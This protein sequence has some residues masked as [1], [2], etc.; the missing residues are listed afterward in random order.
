MKNILLLAIIVLSF[1]CSKQSA[2][3][4]P[5]AKPSETVLKFYGAITR[6]DSATFV[7]LVCSTIKKRFA[8][9]PQFVSYTFEKWKERKPSVKI[10]SES[11]DSTIA[12][13]TY[14]LKTIGKNPIDTTITTQLYLEDGAW[15]FGL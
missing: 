4:S 9:N 13:V 6:Q 8:S 5:T 14:Q 7:Q 15:K 10:I 12:Y 3:T 2:Q 1:G 11:H